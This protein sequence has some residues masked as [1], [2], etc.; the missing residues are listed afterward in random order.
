MSV[1]T[2]R[3]AGNLGLAQTDRDWSRGVWHDFM[4]YS[5]RDGEFPGTIMEFDFTQ[6][7]KT[8]PTTEGNFGPITAFT[9]TGGFINAGTAG[10]WNMGSDGDNEGAS[11]RSRAV[12]FRISRSSGKLWFEARVKKSAIADTKN[13]LF[14][15]LMEDAA[16]TA[17]VP[18]AADGTLADQNLV[19]FHNLEG[20]GDTFDTVY[21]ATGVTAVTVGADAVTIAADTYVKLGMVFEPGIDS[22]IADVSRTGLGTYNLRFFANG[23]PLASYKR[24]PSTA[25]DD[26][27][28][29]VNLGFVLAVL[30][31]TG[32]TPGDVTIERCR[33]AQLH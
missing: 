23:L 5:V 32:S 20:D 22:T 4:L 14:L 25:G 30:N 16:L 13:G 9:S 6:L 10:G 15:G 21:K 19:G 17:T 11:I 2:I 29:D 26:F 31:A 12:P 18:I 7:N 8:P 3:P 27:P 28:N 24:I 1:K 33:I